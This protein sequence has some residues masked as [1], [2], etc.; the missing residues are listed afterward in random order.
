MLMIETQMPTVNSIQMNPIGVLIAITFL[1]SLV[2]VL[3]WMLHLPK[4]TEQT[5]VAEQTVQSVS[6]LRRF[7]VPLLS[8]NDVADRIVALAAQIVQ[9]RDGSIELL[10]VLEVPFMLPLD[11][12]VEED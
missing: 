1:A 3:G 10:A 7:L 6:H 8:T 5:K 12:H 11:A 2:G 9:Y 4:E